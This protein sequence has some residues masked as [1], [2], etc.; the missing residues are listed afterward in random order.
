MNMPSRWKR[1][2]PWI[3]IVKLGV[4]ALLV[5][6]YHKGRLH[7]EVEVLANEGVKKVEATAPKE[8]KVE[9]KVE[10]KTDNYGYLDNLI[11]LPKIEP[12]KMQKE[13]LAK[14]LEIADQAYQKVQLRIEEMKRKAMQLEKIEAIIE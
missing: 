9:K 13:E 14:Y 2:I 3:L 11:H 1:W 4:L 12:E 10:K 7:G 6:E 8:A 5:Y